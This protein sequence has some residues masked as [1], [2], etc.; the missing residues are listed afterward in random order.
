MYSVQLP[1]VLCTLYGDLEYSIRLPG[2]QCTVTW[3]T[4]H[5]VWGPGVNCTMYTVYGYLV[6][7]SKEVNTVP[8]ELSYYPSCAGACSSIQTVY[9]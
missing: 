7:A 8:E 2:V 3:S 4:V 5:T 1:G 6:N 9:L